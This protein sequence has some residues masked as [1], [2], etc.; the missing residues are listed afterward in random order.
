M[1]SMERMTADSALYFWLADKGLAAS[2]ACNH[3][4]PGPNGVCSEHDK[5]IFL[6]AHIRGQ[7]DER[8]RV[9]R[10]EKEK[11]ASTLG[12]KDPALI[13]ESFELSPSDI[14]ALTISGDE[15]QD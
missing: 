10:M 13:V 12:P 8:K 9:I 4:Q 14:D 1:I 2:P 7:M 15:E 11:Q 6:E 5:A 3:G